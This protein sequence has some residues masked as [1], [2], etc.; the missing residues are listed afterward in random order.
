MPVYV[1][2]THLR[3]NKFSIPGIWHEALRLLRLLL[4]QGRSLLQFQKIVYR[5][6]FQ[7]MPLALE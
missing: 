6:L 1:I 7:P 4:Y 5:I 2:Y 3:T